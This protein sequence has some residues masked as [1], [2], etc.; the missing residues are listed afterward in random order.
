MSMA[1][2]KTTVRE[3]ADLIS[4]A[5]RR[6]VYRPA[7]QR[8]GGITRLMSPGDLG[9]LVKP[10]V[11]LDSFDFPSFHGPELPMHPHSGISTHTTLLQGSLDY[12]DSTGKSGRLTPGSIEWMQAGG[13]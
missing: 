7:G 4:Q 3:K 6:I 1:T 10:F 5:P 12:R 2:Q 8:H 13:G 9:E 11:F